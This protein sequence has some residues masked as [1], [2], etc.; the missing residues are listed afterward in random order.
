M[1]KIYWFQ[2]FSKLTSVNFLIP[3]YIRHKSDSCACSS[4]VQCHQQ[5]FLHL[6]TKMEGIRVFHLIKKNEVN[7]L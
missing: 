5:T 2:D 3:V 7:H 4:V 1:V 6:N